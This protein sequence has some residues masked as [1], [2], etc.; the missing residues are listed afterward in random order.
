MRQII[1][2]NL[3]LAFCLCI[4][5]YTFAQLNTGSE[6]SAINKT[7]NLAPKI[8]WETLYYNFGTVKLTERRTHRFTFTNTG[9][10]PVTIEDA[11]PDCPSLKIRF[12]RQSIGPSE[13]GWVEITLEPNE[14][15]QINCMVRVRSNSR[16]LVNILKVSATAQ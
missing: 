16:D 15:Q 4:P 14:P 6:P 5:A 7:K 3:L 9:S 13:K 1:Y 12:S 11:K 10:L 8:I 2:F